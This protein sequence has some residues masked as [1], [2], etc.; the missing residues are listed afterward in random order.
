MSVYV[1]IFQRMRMRGQSM[2]A[3]VRATV[4]Q[5]TKEV[6]KQCPNRPKEVTEQYPNGS[7]EV[8]EQSPNGPFW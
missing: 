8:T 4:F 1:A 7:K 5:Q 3:C 2:R 6:T